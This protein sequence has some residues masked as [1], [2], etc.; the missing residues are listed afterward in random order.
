MSLFCLVLAFFTPELEQIFCIKQLVLERE[1][2]PGVKMAQSKF[3]THQILSLFIFLDDL[4]EENCLSTWT[5]CQKLDSNSHQTDNFL[6]TCPGQLCSS[7]GV[8]SATIA[9]LCDGRYFV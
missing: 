7:S 9:I 3:S 8:K 4:L 6:V 2:M 5:N 1:V